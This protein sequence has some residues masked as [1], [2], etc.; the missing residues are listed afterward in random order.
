MMHID[1]IIWLASGLFTAYLMYGKKEE[2][3]VLRAFLVTIFGVLSL[4][5][6]LI[7]NMNKKIHN[8]LIKK[9]EHQVIPPP[10]ITCEPLLPNKDGKL[11]PM[12]V[13]LGKEYDFKKS[14]KRKAK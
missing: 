12:R 7:W 8:P 4:V 5:I 1:S 9:V 13:V 10:V 11:M 3:S 6:W 14:T 2:I